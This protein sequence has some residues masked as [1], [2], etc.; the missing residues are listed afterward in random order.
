M[1]DSVSAEEQILENNGSSIFTSS[2]SRVKY[3]KKKN[4]GQVWKCSF[5]GS[6]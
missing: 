4:R 6:A 1:A 2:D 3:I 5:P